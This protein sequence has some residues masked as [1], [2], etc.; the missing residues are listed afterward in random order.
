[1][2]ENIKSIIDNVDSASMNIRNLVSRIDKGE[3]LLGTLISDQAIADSVKT[4]LYNL[5]KTSEEA[6][7]A[8]S[9]LAENM[10]A[11]KHNWL[12]KGYFEQRGYWN[13]VEYENEIEK[14]LNELKIQNEILDKKIK[15]MLELESR[16][17]K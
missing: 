6:R 4:L 8:T 1:M 3:G 17:K 14:K 10:E 15:E 11:L 9:S 2:T 5:T 12:F 7:M 16:L 13:K